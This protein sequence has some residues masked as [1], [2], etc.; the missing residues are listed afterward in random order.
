MPAA[1]EHCI[2]AA[3]LRST[4]HWELHKMLAEV[5]GSHRRSF[6]T[7][8]TLTFTRLPL[9]MMNLGAMS[10]LKSRLGPKVSGGVCPARNRSHNCTAGAIKGHQ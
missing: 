4:L 9:A 2:C 10:T 7:K 1:C 6:A 8:F 3:L 5:A